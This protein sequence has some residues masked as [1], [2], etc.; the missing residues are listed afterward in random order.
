MKQKCSSLFL[1]LIIIFFSG[2]DLFASEKDT[3]VVNVTKIIT[4]KIEKARWLK[5]SVARA[6]LFNIPTMVAVFEGDRVDVS[7]T[8]GEDPQIFS[9][10]IAKSIIAKALLNKYKT[11][12]TFTI[13][14]L[15]DE[16]I[17]KQKTD[18]YILRNY[19]SYV[20]NKRKPVFVVSTEI[21]RK[22][23][24]NI[25]GKSF[26]DSI[27]ISLRETNADTAKKVV[28]KKKKKRVSWF[29][30]KKKKGSPNLV[31][32]DS[33][34]IDIDTSKIKDT[35]TEVFVGTDS[36]HSFHE[37]SSKSIASIVFMLVILFLV[38]SF[39]LF[40]ILGKRE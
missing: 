24:F 30:R 32:T 25:V 36:T 26:Q 33:S 14:T 16:N 9:K 7:K 38:I 13:D 11:F 29:K 27:L 4:S 20:K 22:V 1:I 15:F 28:A 37:E 6:D 17:E 5:N 40:W 31:I 10:V 12:N 34:K 39:L 23:S 19:I 8:D 35:V 3:L 2:N 21:L 18:L